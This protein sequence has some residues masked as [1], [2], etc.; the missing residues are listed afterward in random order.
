[1]GSDGTVIAR[2]EWQPAHSSRAVA[3]DLFE[4]EGQ[5]AAVSDGAT[6]ASGPRSEVGITPR[7]GSIPR[8]LTFIDG[9]VF[10]T[11]DNGAIDALVSRHGGKGSGLVYRMEQFHPRLIAFTLAVILLAVGIYRYA[12][13]VMVEVAILVTPPVVPE[14]IGAS[15]LATLE[16]TLLRPTALPEVDQ[17]AIRA[18]FAALAKNARGGEP[19]YTLLFRNARLMGPNAFALPDGTLVLTDDLVEL[20]KGDRQM[21]LGVLG[22]EIAH[23]EGDHSLRQIYRVAGFAALVM[24]IAGDVGSGVEDILSQGGALVA[25][26]YS[27]GAEEDADRRSV[28]L[29]KAAGYEPAALAR[30]FAIL[31][32]KM[33][34]HDETSM[35][36]THPGTPARQRYIREYAQQLEGAVNDP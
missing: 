26:S 22:H 20:S 23:V 16:K 30:F 15:T 17:N 35:L 21:V 11:R 1:M 33:S 19:A 10:E 34:D 14:M 29:M 7:V 5:L 27:R 2:G 18:E 32:E 28:E 24:L 13:P 6:L 36:S 12:L 25:L 4:K 8:R 3:A 31:E 9:S